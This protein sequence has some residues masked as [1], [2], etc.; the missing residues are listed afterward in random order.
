MIHIEGSNYHFFLCTPDSVARVKTTQSPFY[1]F[2]PNQIEELPYLYSQ[3]SMIPKFLYK[4][5]YSRRTYESEPMHSPAYISYK[6][7]NLSLEETRFPEGTR[8]LSGGKLYLIKKHPYSPIGK[9]PIYLL[10]AP[11]HSTQIGPIQTGKF[12]LVRLDRTRQISTRYLSLRDIVNP[13]LDEKS[14]SKKIEELYFD[15]ESKSYLFRLVKILYAGTPAEEQTIVSNLFS[16]EPEFA[17]FLRDKIFT[18]EILPLIHG[19]FLNSILNIMD[20][21]LLKFSIARLSSP[22]KRMV[23]KNVSKN[24]WKSI[25]SSPAKKPDPGESFEE[26][27]EKE[28]FRRF[29]RKIYYEEGI[30]PVYAIA[31]NEEQISLGTRKEVHFQTIPAEK[32]NLNLVGHGI[33]LFAVTQEKILFRV[34]QSLEVFRADLLISKRE[35]DSVEYYK[36][37]ENSILEIPRYD[38]TKLVVGGGIGADRKPVEFSLLSYNY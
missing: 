17:S 33:E 12:T 27:V 34:G 29:S 2:D 18:I 15:K 25:Q 6:N 37:P 8:E 4:L 36:I 31:R 16:K 10:T 7:G 19:P 20:E 3:P 5:E 23:E 35:R 26:I 22:V 32:Y 28:I 1:D 9:I 11:S 30:F 38:Q 13:E 21:R 14:V 24:K